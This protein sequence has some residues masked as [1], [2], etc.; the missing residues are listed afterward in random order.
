MPTVASGHDTTSAAGSWEGST[1]WVVYSEFNHRVAGLFILLFG[2]AELILA[3]QMPTSRWIR[4]VRPG[5][6]GVVGAFLLAWSDHEAW[7]IESFRQSVGDR[8]G[9]PHSSDRGA[10]ARLFRIDGHHRLL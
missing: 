10:V 6:L 1:Q 9:M 3:V 5:A 2:L 7:H 8:L 4:F